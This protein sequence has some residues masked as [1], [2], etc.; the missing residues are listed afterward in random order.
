MFFQRKQNMVPMD[1]DEHT[2]L[3]LAKQEQEPTLRYQLLMRAKELAPGSLPVQR[4]LLMHGRLHE[5]DARHPDFSVI[6]CYLLHVFEHPEQHQEEDIRNKTRELFDHPD[7]LSCL[8]LAENPDGFLRDYL[9]E[10]SETYIRMFLEGDSSNVP[11]LFGLTRKHS[12]PRY[13]A[14][15]MADII[16][17]MLSS[18]Y[19]RVSEQQLAASTFYRACHRHLKGDTAFLDASLSPEVIRQLQ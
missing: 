7:L 14:P 19:L 18:A 10:M 8:A 12:I 3:A 2:L 1:A 17:N 11:S 16:H 9:E 15:P 5:R 4:A 13:L 6:K